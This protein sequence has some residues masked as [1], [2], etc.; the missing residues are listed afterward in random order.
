L[1]SFVSP[2]A[3]A[4]GAKPDPG[5]GLTFSSA[6]RKAS[7]ITI[8]PNVW[9]YVEAGKPP[10]PFLAAGNFTAIWEGFLNADLRGS[11]LFRA[12]LSGSLKI[13]INGA[14]VL[15]AIGAGGASPLSKP[16]Q[17]NKGPNAFKAT[18]SSPA[19]GDAFVRLAWTE[20]AP[21][22][23]PI[24]DAALTHAPTLEVKQ[25]VQRYL[26]RELFFN[27][28]CVKCH[29]E[30]TADSS[31]PELKMDGPSFEGI[32]ARRHYEWMTRWILDP[33]SVRPA[34][35]MPK[36]LHGPA[37]KEDAAAIAAYL[38]SLKNEPAVKFAA[39]LVTRQSTPKE[40]EGAA[41]SGEAKPIY[42]R[43]R[44]AGCHNPPDA[45]E[46]DPAKLSQKGVGTKFPRGKLAE[47]LRAPE[48]HYAWTRMPNFRLSEQEAKELEDYL[49]TASD[50]P[51]DAVAPTDA[52]ILER[53]RQL[54]QTTG[55]LNCHG[56]LK[57]ENQFRTP[58]L[59]ALPSRHLKDRSKLPPG[60]CLGATPA[61][62]Y[63]FTA[64]QR[65]ALDTFT[66]DGLPSLSR[67]APAEFAQRQTRLLNCNACHGQIDLVPTFE[68][69]GGKLKPE[70][71]AKFIAGDFPHKIRYDTHPKGEPWVAARMPAFPAQAKWLA[72]GLAQLHGYAPKT[73]TEPPVEAELAK[74]GQKLVG[75]DGGFSCISCHAVGPAL[76]TEVFESEGVNFAYSADRL[77]PDFYRRW[78]RNPLAIEPQ[79]KMPVYFDEEGKSPLTEILGGDGDAQLAAMWEYL[80]LRDKMPAPKT[81]VE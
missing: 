48:A 15:E 79:T 10:T 20:K 57:L 51:K 68:T 9:L 52:A 12:D 59:N 27:S 41:P 21:Y 36:L 64:D 28:R 74:Q 61:A 45:T 11:Y 50:K 31:A 62:D 7:D 75:K 18:F 77:L 37:A 72:E 22:T 8:A 25:S 80:R 2:P 56:G 32:G 63:G 29:T 16:V 38:A 5:L 73:L 1:F 3:A 23:G 42:E 71:T 53:G 76:A 17:L 70:W 66:I 33:R 67:H 44:C 78:V 43:L 13:E 60:D 54:V 6:D 47:F 46:I 26:G 24:P 40:G 39:P 49:L 69:L 35:H 14:V 58:P 65:A 30:T 34:A 55:C 4:A 19:Q 81:G